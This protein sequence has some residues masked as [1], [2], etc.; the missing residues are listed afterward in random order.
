MSINFNNASWSSLVT[1]LRA[2]LGLANALL[3]VRLVGVEAYGQMVTVLSVFVI[4]LSLNTNLYTIVVIKLTSYA[5][6]EQQ[7]ERSEILMAATLLTASSLLILGVT[8]AL[9]YWQ[10]PDL[11]RFGGSTNDG[12]LLL[13]GALCGVQI[14]AALQG[15]LV[16]ASGRLD[17]TMKAQLIGPAALLA[18]LTT[19]VLLNRH[20]TGKEYLEILCVSAVLDL[21]VIW[22]IRRLKAGPIRWRS[23][24]PKTIKQLSV[25][26]SAGSPLQATALMNL[27]LDPLN[28]ILLGYFNEAA[29][30][31]I[32]DLAMKIIWGI[33]SLFTSAMRVFLHFNGVSESRINQAYLHVISL[34]VVPTL[35]IH[36][37]GAA[38][39][40]CVANWWVSIDL[41]SLLLFYS[42]ATM[43]NLGMILITPLYIRLINLQDLGFIVKSQTILAFVNTAISILTIP[44]FGLLGAAI[45]LLIATLYNVPAIYRRYQRQ[46]APLN[47]L[48]KLLTSALILRVAV[49]LGLFAATI[50]AAMFGRLSLLLAVTLGA[51]LFLMIII[52]PLTRRIVRSLYVN[53]MGKRTDA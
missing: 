29:S 16:E 33:Q 11:L 44:L 39:L 20:I 53:A 7:S 30:V 1:G 35:I 31:T 41:Q 28:R 26:V 32:Y 27:F 45:G 49:A 21:G 22:L 10:S 13:M 15:A 23:F 18:I 6:L 9:I 34:I 24:G 36:T 38:F 12:L 4:Y 40:Y 51:S 37:V 46:V 47:G 5:G 48:T 52:E 42:L 43:S 50:Y 8:T 17:L 3:A 25:L 2:V 14:L 19:M